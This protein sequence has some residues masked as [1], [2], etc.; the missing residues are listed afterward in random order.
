MN[1]SRD[2]FASIAPTVD[3]RAGLATLLNGM[4][5]TT[6]RRRVV[7]SAIA[8]TCALALAGALVGVK[9]SRQD[10]K[11]S[12]RNTGTTAAT[13]PSTTPDTTTAPTTT[14]FVA[15]PNVRCP[16]PPLH[17]PRW[18]EATN[19]AYGQS[20]G[21]LRGD[22]DIAQRYVSSLDDGFDIEYALVVPARLTVRVSG[23]VEETRSALSTMLSHPDQVDIALVPFTKAD[24]KRVSADIVAE[25]QANASLFTEYSGL[26]EDG[27]I[28]SVLNIGLKPGQEARAAEYVERWGPIVRIEIGGQP[29]VPKGCG[30]QPV[31]PSCPDAS[32][33]DPAL[34]QLELSLTSDQPTFT[35]SDTGTA[36]LRIRNIGSE[37]FEAETGNVLVGV[38]VEPQTR[39]VVGRFTGGLAGVGLR[40]TVPPGESADVRVI[41]GASRCDGGEGSALPP[42]IYGLRV[43]IGDN[44]NEP[45][46]GYLSPEI[47][48]TLTAA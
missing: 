26:V 9:N 47:P 2:K 36:M 16:A 3:E 35:V 18:D 32:G 15:D 23:R 46:S 6:R 25:A 7:R 41:F 48:V 29:Y 31:A 38:L 17:F 28:P 34:A 10:D 1:T 20:Q 39:H 37:S 4:R 44:P 22:A 24:V 45:G 40:T 30:P 21:E 43:V 19:D 5:R 8:A 33:A 13:A 14:S 12:T 11:V 42:G 27:R